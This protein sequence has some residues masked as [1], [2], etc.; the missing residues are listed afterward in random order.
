VNV[1]WV[2]FTLAIVASVVSLVVRYRAGTRTVRLQIKWLF[3]AGAVAAACQIV[4]LTAMTLG[5]GLN[6]ALVASAYGVLTAVVLLGVPASITLAILWHGLYQ[7]DVI[8]SRG[9][10]VGLRAAVRTGVS[11]AIVIGIGTLAGY[12]GGSGLSVAAAVTVAL[13]FQPV[14]Q[15]AQR[16]ANRLVYGERASPYQVLADFAE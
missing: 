14:R 5:E 11:V 1:L 13:L 3:L 9:V 7:I 2:V 16:I 8:I 10:Q 15:R 6:S 4:A 12:S